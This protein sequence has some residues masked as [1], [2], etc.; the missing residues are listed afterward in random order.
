MKYRSLVS[1]EADSACVSACVRPCT[2]VRVRA[3]VIMRTS[4]YAVVFFNLFENLPPSH[5]NGHVETFSLPIHTFS[6]SQ[7]RAHTF[8]SH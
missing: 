8:A 4:E 3:C 2:C 7:L 1:F 6:W 5:S